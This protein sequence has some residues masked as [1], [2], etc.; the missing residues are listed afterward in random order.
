MPDDHG[1]TR[2]PERTR[3][4]ALPWIA[5]PEPFRVY[6]D[7]VLLAIRIFQTARADA[8]RP[9][10]SAGRQ[11]FALAIAV[12]AEHSDIQAQVDAAPRE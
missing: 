5:R 9:L 10:S 3:V 11:L 1:L 4:P 12:I 2:V 7:D 6:P 8:E